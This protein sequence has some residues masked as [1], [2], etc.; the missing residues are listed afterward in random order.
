M[1]SGRTCAIVPVKALEQAKRRLSSVLPD[2]AR[3]Q[4]VLAM[5]Q[6]VLAALAG[7]G[8]IDWAV[9]VTGDQRA[10][11]GNRAAGGRRRAHRLA[12]WW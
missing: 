9:V 3:Q 4:L 6:D 12:R 10:A 1:S 11:Q 5:L 7:V 8:S 2:A